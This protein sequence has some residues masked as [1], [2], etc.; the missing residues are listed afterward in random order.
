[1]S[2]DQIVESLVELAK[3]FRVHPMKNGDMLKAIK[4]RN[5]VISFIL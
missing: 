3:N 2:R 1:M 5:H 4:E